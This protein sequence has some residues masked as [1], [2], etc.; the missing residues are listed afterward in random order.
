MKKSELYEMIQA[1]RLEIDRLKNGTAQ[2]LSKHQKMYMSDINGILE[3]IGNI[4]NAIITQND[5]IREVE[6]VIQSI[7]IVKTHSI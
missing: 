2:L 3:K 5:R 7:K 6:K 1:Q 4:E